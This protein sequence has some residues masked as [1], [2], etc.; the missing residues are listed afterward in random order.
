MHRAVDLDEVVR[1]LRDR[2]HVERLAADGQPELEPARSLDIHLHRTT[3]KIHVIPVWSATR[4]PQPVGLAARADV[5]LVER[6]VPDFRTPARGGS[7]QAVLLASGVRLVGLER[8]GQQGDVDPPRRGVTV[9]HHRVEPGRVDLAAH[10]LRPLQQVEQEGLV[11]GPAAD[12]RDGLPDRAGQPGAGLGAVP[13]PGDHLGD[14][15]VELRRDDVTWGHSGVDPDP[16]PAGSARCSIRPGAGAKS[17]S[18]SSAVSLA[19]MAC[20]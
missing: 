14:H 4:H 7:E 20:P 19:S 3:V 12:D 6:L 5:D 15:G 1:A 17:R 11:R 9:G 13:A 16:G 8:G 18:G 2:Q 10:E